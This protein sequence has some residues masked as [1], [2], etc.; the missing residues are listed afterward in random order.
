MLKNWRR[1]KFK[2]GFLVIKMRQ[3]RK[4]E[5]IQQALSLD[6]GPVAN[7]FNDVHLI[8][9]A[10]PGLNSQEIDLSVE[11][12]GKTLKMPLLINAITGGNPLVTEI[13]RRL[14]QIAAQ[15]GIAIA[16]GSQGAALGKNSGEKE[17]ADDAVLI[18]SYRVMRLENP[19]GVVIANISAG[20][21]LKGAWRAIEMIEADAL[22]IHLNPA[23]EMA[24]QEG[25]R[26][27]SCWAKNIE[28]IVKACPVP[29]IVKEVG[30]GISWEVSYK[31]LELG[32]RY[33]DIGG[34]GG[35]NFVKIELGRNDR[36][37]P[38]FETWGIPS[39]ISL[40]EVVWAKERYGK[41]AGDI[42]VIAS[43]GIRQG[44]EAVKAL[45][46]GAK[47]VGIAGAV[48]KHLF[49]VQVHSCKAKPS[50]RYGEPCLKCNQG[51]EFLLSLKSGGFDL[52]AVQEYLTN[53]RQDMLVNMALTGCLKPED[54]QKLPCIVTGLA[55]D[56][57]EQRRIPVSFWADRGGERA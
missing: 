24:M 25:D 41:S 44:W 20:T 22:Q 47:L 33:I 43:G 55:K 57:L 19:R 26:D 1:R 28:Q 7:G 12:L 51:E 54:L 29:V 15:A 32:V 38:E 50:R 42:T 16:V 6:D 40:A 27:F 30:F 49:F 23:Q 21:D 4:L 45:A 14:A 13:N 36:R 10:L 8:H 5:H 2:G 9:N 18:D 31:L 3:Q 34:A 52:T 48:L 56:W 17:S 46:M 35:T 37:S 39:A 11:F 53:L